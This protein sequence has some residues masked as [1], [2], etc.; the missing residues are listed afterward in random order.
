MLISHIIFQV[1]GNLNLRLLHVG[2]TLYLSLE[3]FF[4]SFFNPNYEGTRILYLLV[5]DVFRNLVEFSLGTQT[6]HSGQIGGTLRNEQ[7]I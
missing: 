4:D 3:L 1:L 6:R 7:F 2:N 5:E